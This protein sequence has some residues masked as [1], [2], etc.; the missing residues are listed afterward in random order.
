[1]ARHDR[2]AIARTAIEVLVPLLRSNGEYHPAEAG[3]P[4]RW[5]LQWRG[6]H[7]SLVGQV[8]LLPDDDAQSALLDIWPTKGQKVL[9]VRWMPSKPWLSPQIVSFRP[10]EWLT[11][12]SQEL[13]R[14]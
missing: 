5:T 6:L 2:L 7:V 9:S 1:M 13:E 10:G 11:S 4:S 14:P 3:L 12:L 8:L